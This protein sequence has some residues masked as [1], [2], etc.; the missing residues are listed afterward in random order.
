MCSV[1]VFFCWLLKVFPCESHWH[2]HR[3][4]VG[5]TQLGDTVQKDGGH[6]LVL[7]LHKAEHFKSEAAHL[8]LPVLKDGGLGIFFTADS[9]KW[10]NLVR[11][12]KRNGHN[13]ISHTSP[14]EKIIAKIITGVS[15]RCGVTVV[16]QNV[17]P[18]QGR[19]GT[20]VG[21]ETFAWCL[22]ELTAYLLLRGDNR[23][24]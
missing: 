22:Q 16:H 24:S 13:L 21:M 10:E 17:P 1:W 4:V 3:T 14:K 6:L 7:V 23:F 15:R 8:A 11:K 9:V 18:V 19:S 12:E 2:D 5:A 20:L